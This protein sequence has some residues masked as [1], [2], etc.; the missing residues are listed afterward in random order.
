M[1][2]IERNILI[3][4][5]SQTGTAQDVAERIGREAWRRHFGARCFAM[6][7]YQISN[8]L[9]ER[10]VVFVAATTGQ[11]DEP[12]SMKK[13]WRFLLRKSLPANS[14]SNVNCAVL[15][16]GDSSYQKF[17]FVGKKLYRRL[18]QLGAS[19]LLDLGLADDQHDLGPDAVVDPWSGK[20]WGRLEELCPL[21]VGMTPLP[22][23]SIPPPR[24]N[25][26]LTKAS[27]EVRAPSWSKEL[28]TDP[29]AT[30]PYHARMVANE[31]LTSPDH[32]Q[33]VR[34]I[35][36]DIA[37]SGMKYAAGDVLMV[38]PQNSE[39][40]VDEFLQVMNLDPD[41]GVT[42]TPSSTEAPL[43]TCL[44][45]ESTV[46]WLVT[47]YF[48]IQS[49]P[50]RS[51]FEFLAHFAQGEME[52]EKLAEFTTPEGQEELFSYCNRPRRSITEVLSDFHTVAKC[53]PLEYLFDII[54]ALQPRAF[55]IASS[56]R[57]HPGQV[58]ILMAV[59]EYKTKLFKPRKGVC[60]TWLAS[61]TPSSAV[62][63]PV[64]AV[65][66]TLT[67]QRALHRPVVMVGPGT[68]CAPFRAFMEERLAAGMT[69]TM[70]FFGC[71]SEKADH[72]FSKEWSSLVAEDKLV[73]FTAFSR[74]QEHKVYV[75][76][77]MEEQGRLLWEWI[78]CKEAYI[79]I[80][81]NSKRMPIDVLDALKEVVAN[82][83]HTSKEDSEQFVKSLE[84][85]SSQLQWLCIR[86]SSCFAVRRKS[87][88]RVA[89]S[90][91]PNNVA[92]KHAYKYSSVQKKT[93]G[94]NSAPDNK[95]VVLVTKRTKYVR[96]PAKMFVT[97]R[98]ARDGRRAFR[99]IRRN[100][101]KSGYRRDLIEPAV[102]RASAL[103]A[104]QKPRKTRSKKA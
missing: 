86:N 13:F 81:G 75:Q 54:P 8:L 9:Y 100:L 67:L 92:N 60:S 98:L 6:D 48:D 46:K 73:L 37:E 58:Q 83:G 23:D 22:A 90:T 52:K 18:L 62:R 15:G 2:S 71:R 30:F 104:S 70:L 21:P 14:L 5:G 12:D 44:P 55:S 33:D 53:I 66:G 40:A 103:L 47:H 4:F 10:L 57:M 76:H 95:G 43:A 65:P 45:R 101:G 42:L 78:D 34:L 96:R 77:R 80:A 11:G 89:F 39:E 17:N 32:F 20:L 31:R 1:T 49:I 51:F 68:G 63:V 29:S 28:D 102:R 93:V 74:D 84:A 87:C 7:E 26:S 91:E 72:F 19:S 27:E 56:L 3:L 94:V 25:V 97:T 24:Y 59:V 36:F 41:Q 88:G 82:F 99:S 16:L 61:V 50:R 69:D 35:T 85:M 38:R 79:F 64:W